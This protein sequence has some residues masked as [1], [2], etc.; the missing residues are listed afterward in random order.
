[1]KRHSFFIFHFSFFTY[2]ACLLLVCLFGCGESRTSVMNKEEARAVMDDVSRRNLAYEPLTEHDDTMMQ[3]VVTYYNKYG[4]HNE[5]MEAY[6]LLGSVCRDLRDAPRAMEAFLNGISAAD[7]TSADCR[8][9]LLA[10]LYGQKCN[11]LYKQNLHKLAIEADRWVYKY[12]VLAKDTIYIVATQWGRLGKCFA[13]GDYQTVADESWSVLKES[14]RMG[15]FSYSTKHLCTSILANMELGRVED[16]QKLLSIYEQ[17]SGCVDMKTHECSF[18]I[19]YYAKGRVLAATGQL[20]SAEYFFRKELETQDWDNRQAAYRGLRMLFEQKGLTDSICKYAPLQCNAVDSSYQEML[21][22]NLQNLQELY[23]YN[24]LQA[25]N[26]QKELQLQ[27]SRRKSLYI[28]CILAFVVICGMFLFLYLRS[29]YRQRIASAELD[30]ERANAGLE[31]R[32]NNLTAL[33]EELAKVRDE[34]ERLRLARE[35]EQ[36]EKETEEQRKVVMEDQKKLDELR[37]HAKTN[38]K[39]LRQQYCSTPLFKSLLNEIR[40]NKVATGQDYEQI[41]QVL[42]EKD[43]E[44]MQ[45]FYAVLPHS[46]A[47][48]LQVFLLLR[49][50]LAKTEIGSL[51]AH[52]QAA[53]T[54]IVTRLFQKIHG[55]ACSTSAEAYEWLLKI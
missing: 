19:Y 38:S 48:E 24:R 32:E 36:A 33:R 8:Y 14:K 17:H 54:N 1:M 28:G 25:V 16:A 42:T 29:Y 21:S 51:M 35:V 26:N 10:R 47:T 23:D 7:T 20:D 12:A 2:I 34:E 9:D 40:N 6:Y 22:Q 13:C 41:Q 5:Q 37:Q 4:T 46:S 31:E 18:P 43:A 27:E 55:R 45:R 53:V 49:F 15:M 11:I 50:G 39:S 52:T 44:L 30:L 3:H